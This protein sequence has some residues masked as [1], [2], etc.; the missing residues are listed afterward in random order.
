MATG[1]GKDTKQALLR[2]LPAEHFAAI[3]R[4]MSK[5]LGSQLALK[6]YSQVPMAWGNSDVDKWW[7]RDDLRQ[8]P[9]QEASDIAKA[10]LAQF[11]VEEC[12]IDAEVG[13]TNI[14]LNLLIVTFLLGCGT[15]SR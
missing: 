10:F 13:T 7:L 5:I 4:A 11:R 15:I 6:T 2:T 1:T 14:P 12:C 8:E 3:R 9:S